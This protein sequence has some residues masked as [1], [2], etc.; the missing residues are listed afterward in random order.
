MYKQFIFLVTSI[1]TVLPQVSI[2]APKGFQSPSGNMFCELIP[3]ERVFCYLLM[4][5]QKFCV[6]VILSLIKI[7]PFWLMDGLGTMVVLNVYPKKQ[8]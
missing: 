7:N 5:D 1:V 4:L 6:L 2:A 3:G 8:V